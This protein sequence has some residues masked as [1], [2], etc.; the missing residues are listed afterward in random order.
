[1]NMAKM[2]LLITVALL[3]ACG[4]GEGGKCAK[5]QDCNKGLV[6]KLAKFK[7]I[8]PQKLSICKKECSE[9]ATDSSICK[10]DCERAAVGEKPAPRIEESSCR[11]ACKLSQKDPKSGPEFIK[12]HWSKYGEPAYSRCFESE[13]QNELECNNV[14]IDACAKSCE[15]KHPEKK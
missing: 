12:F 3:I 6:C 8:D 14:A 5:D 10:S 1:M 7:C 4:S 2:V 15:F 11:S 13:P 9:S